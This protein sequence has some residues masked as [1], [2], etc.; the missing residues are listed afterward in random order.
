MTQ[1]NQVKTIELPPPEPPILNR[2]VT[3]CLLPAD[4]GRETPMVWSLGRENPLDPKM[5]VIRMLL[6]DDGDVEVYSMP[7]NGAGDTYWRHTIPR[8]MVRVVQEMMPVDIWIDELI[9][10]ETGDDD[11]PDDPDPELEPNGPSPIE[12][13]SNGQATP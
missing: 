3:Q 4:D 9:D 12:Q 8:H 6:T 5:K 13:S 11:D 2:M 7:S 10:A 1:S